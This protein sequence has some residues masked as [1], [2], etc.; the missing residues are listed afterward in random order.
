MKTKINFF[1]ELIL[2]ILLSTFILA[3]DSCPAGMRRT[4][5]DDQSMVSYGSARAWYS[6]VCYFQWPGALFFRRKVLIEPRF[7]VH[8]KAALEKS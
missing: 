7:E 6:A 2:L 3:E 4:Y 8:L 5:V 1:V